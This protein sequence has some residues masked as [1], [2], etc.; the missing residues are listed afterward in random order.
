MSYSPAQLVQ[1][2]LT[3]QVSPPVGSLP[4]QGVVWPVYVSSMP[5]DVDQ[6]VAIYDTKGMT[7]GRNMRT[8]EK[9][10]RP[11]IMVRIRAAGPE[12]P[13][14]AIDFGMLIVAAFD[15]VKNLTFSIGNT[16]VTIAAISRQGNLVFA[17]E[18]PERQRV[19]Y[20]LDAI[21][22]ATGY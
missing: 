6:C 15:V 21:V 5:Q 7:Y 13:Q 18:E 11:G 2:Y 3:E 16:E 10:V 9:V 4:P 22:I 1:H 20:T 19:I 17:G 12:G 14:G 8:G